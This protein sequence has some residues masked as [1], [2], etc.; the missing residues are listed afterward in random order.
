MPDFKGDKLFVNLGASQTRRRL[1]GFGHGVRKI[2]SAG[3]NQAVII[4]TATGR[5]L[6]ELQSLFSDV[7]FNSVEPGRQGGRGAHE[8]ETASAKEEE[9]RQVDR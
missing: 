2:Q 1:K 3:R 5:H 7:G 6:Q 9:E 8:F 4:H